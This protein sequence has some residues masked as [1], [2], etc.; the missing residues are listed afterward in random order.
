MTEQ[1]FFQAIEQMGFNQNMET[2]RALHG[3]ALQVFDSPSIGILE[4]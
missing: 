2:I 1:Q 3:M 4:F